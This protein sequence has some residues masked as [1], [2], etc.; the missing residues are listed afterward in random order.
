MSAPTIE[1]GARLLNLNVLDV[2]PEDQ[3]PVQCQV[4]DWTEWSPQCPPPLHECGRPTQRRSRTIL[5][6]PS[7]GGN[8]CPAT[9]DVRYCQGDYTP[10]PSDFPT[11]WF[12]T[13]DQN[14]R[15]AVDMDIS[16]RTI[17]F[18][19]N[20]T[21]FSACI[22]DHYGYQ[23]LEGFSGATKLE[24]GDDSFVEITLGDA[25]FP[26]LGNVKQTIFVGSNGYLTLD[27]GDFSYMVGESG[28]P[29]LPQAAG[30]TEDG[31]ASMRRL[32]SGHRNV[33]ASTT[34][35]GI[36]A[37]FAHIHQ[38]VKRMLAASPNI[39]GHDQF[40]QKTAPHW[41]RQRIAGLYQDMNPTNCDFTCTH[42]VYFQVTNHFF[43]SSPSHLHPILPH[44][45][46]FSDTL[47]HSLSIYILWLLVD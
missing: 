34:G 17:K 16:G 4:S 37:A 5:A 38:D 30:V 40:V 27:Q 1:Q 39:E 21:A 15:P 25:G 9:Q 45:F 3:D 18:S 35:T 22:D 2:C 14:V 19:P 8:V 20:S 13:T 11:Q 41:L 6:E 28:A 46:S 42:G 43:P 29:G 23:A 32:L 47:S 24:M 10:C 26:Y 44:F 7:C 12:G 36:K 31:E 33:S